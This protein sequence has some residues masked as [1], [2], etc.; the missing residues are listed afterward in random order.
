MNKLFIIIGIAVLL[1][2]GGIAWKQSATEPAGPINDT[3]SIIINDLTTID[4]GDVEN[5]EW[6]DIDKEIQKL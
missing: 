1:I 2:G 4:L 6:E 3:T 5:S